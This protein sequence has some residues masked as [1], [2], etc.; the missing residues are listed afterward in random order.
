MKDFPPPF[1]GKSATANLYEKEQSTFR[2]ADR[3]VIPAVE[4]PPV[5]GEESVGPALYDLVRETRRAYEANSELLREAIHAGHKR[6]VIEATSGETDANGNLDLR[7]FQVPQGHHFTVTRV[8]VEAGLFTPASP[9]SAATAWI[10]LIRGALFAQG[11][12]LDFGPPASGGVILPS[13]FS[14][15]DS[16]AP[17]LNGGEI[18]SLHIVGSITL[19]N[20]GI[21]A[22]CQ[23]IL[24]LI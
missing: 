8:N 12:I 6:N 9:F 19:A 5:P 10:A 20:T 3:Q 18:L 15:S 24:T 1:G 7:L 22:R 23:G 14:T 16:H 21:W 11:S 2:D 4:R 13:I 17:A